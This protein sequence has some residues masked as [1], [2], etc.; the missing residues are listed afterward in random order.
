MSQ[1]PGHLDQIQLAQG[2]D[3]T[4]HR[5]YGFPTSSVVCFVNTYSLD[6][7]LSD[8]LRYPPLNNVGPGKRRVQNRN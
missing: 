3:N 5:I 4:V 7:D 6:S 8:G 2:M 1:T